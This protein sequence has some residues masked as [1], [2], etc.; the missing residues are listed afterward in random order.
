[1][2]LAYY[3]YRYLDP[4]SHIVYSFFVGIPQRDIQELTRDQTNPNPGKIIL[5]KLSDSEKKQLKEMLGIDVSPD[6][7]RV[8]PIAPLSETLYF[9]LFAR[10]KAHAWHLLSTGFEL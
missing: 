6:T 7:F 3:G 10:G 8:L 4:V 1:M 9:V 5:E 2:P